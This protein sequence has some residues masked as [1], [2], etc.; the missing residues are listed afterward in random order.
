MIKELVPLRFVLI[1]MIFFHHA[2]GFAGGG[3]SAVA[4][5]FVLSG[6]CMMLGYRDKVLKSNFSYAKY[7]KKRF[8]KT[9]PLHWV[10]LTVCVGL[11]IWQEH[12]FG[13]IRTLLT[14]ALL[15]Q[16]WLPNDGI[17]FSYNAVSWYLSTALLAIVLF[18]MLVGFLE[19]L[20]MRDRGVF[21]GLI[22]LAYAVIIYRMPSDDRHAMLYIHP[23]ARLVD[24]I[25]GMY[26]AYGYMLLKD[27]NRVMDWAKRHGVLLDMGFMFFLGVFLVE[28]MVVKE[29]L[30]PIA[31]L[32]WLPIAL[33][34]LF[35]CMGRESGTLLHKIMQNKYVGIMTQCSFS[36]MMWHQLVL[37][38]INTPPLWLRMGQC[39]D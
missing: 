23:V 35:L 25:L 33:S 7:I 19:R 11:M 18:P 21:G 12:S 8:A 13:S 37:R 30:H 14:N 38:Y 29:S 4:Y 6:F 2:A 32:I 26:L 22:L 34:L 16:S 10:T 20:T 17:Y 24:F 9:F 3:W 31:G 28:A 39:V 5:F 1:L 27:N 15:L 36:L